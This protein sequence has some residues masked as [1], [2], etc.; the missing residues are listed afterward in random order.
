MSHERL[1]NRQPLVIGVGNPDCADDGL[2]AL[3][4]SKLARMTDAQVILRRGDLLILIED[5][6]RADSVVLIDAAVGSAR[7]GT[8]HRLDLSAKALPREL[9]HSSTHAFGLAEAV[10]LAR[11]LGR[12]PERIVLYAIEATRFEPGAPLSEQAAEAADRAAQL[13]AADLRGARTAQ[14]FFV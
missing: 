14:P 7:P 11:A 3:I 12:L 4:A 13:I 8:I 2:G 1:R 5:W 9:T 6:A 10:E